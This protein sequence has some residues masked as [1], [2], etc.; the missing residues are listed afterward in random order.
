MIETGQ[1]RA[2]NYCVIYSI[3]TGHYGIVYKAHWVKQH[4]QGRRDTCKHSVKAVAIKVMKGSQLHSYKCMKYV[5]SCI[6][7][8][9]G[10]GIDTV[11]PMYKCGLP[12][13]QKPL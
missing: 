6:E 7:Y 11:E 8:I 13:M 12:E 4:Q 9:I 5:S 3:P 10:E 1:E 2:D